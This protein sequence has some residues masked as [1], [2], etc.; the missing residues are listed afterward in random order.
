M[1]EVPRFLTLEDVI[2][3][4]NLQIENVDQN[5]SRNIKRTQLYLK[6]N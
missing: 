4:A 6:N 1:S 2:V 5:L 3:P